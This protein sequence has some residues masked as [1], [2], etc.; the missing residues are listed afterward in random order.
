MPT[1]AVH[2]CTCMGPTP[3]NRRNMIVVIAI[4]TVLITT[5]K[6]ASR[7]LTTTGSNE[8]TTVPA[9][10]TAM[11]TV[12]HRPMRSPRKITARMAPNGMKSWVAMAAEETSPDIPSPEKFS[13]KCKT[14]TMKP[15][16]TTGPILSRG[17][18]RNGNRRTASKT[19]RRSS[20][21]NVGK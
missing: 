8:M 6:S 17:T 10:A 5:T 1:T 20:I 21:S 4:G 18:R 12:R 3:V 9:N 14:P 7:W 11:A 15:T 13:E 2:A 19:K 16:A